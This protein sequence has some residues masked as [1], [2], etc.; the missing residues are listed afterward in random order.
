MFEDI[1]K[2]NKKLLL[3]IFISILLLGFLPKTSL[4]ALSITEPSGGR[5]GVRFNVTW[6]PDPLVPG[7]GLYYELQYVDE[8][9][10]L[11]TWEFDV[12]VTSNYYE[13]DLSLKPN[14]SVYC[15]RVRAWNSS[16]FGTWTCDPGAPPGNFAGCNCGTVIKDF[17]G[18]VWVNTSPRYIN[19]EVA[20]INVTWGVTGSPS[21]AK[22]FEVNYTVLDENDNMVYNWT[23]WDMNDMYDVLVWYG[24]VN[25]DTVDCTS[26]Y[27]DVFRPAIVLGEDLE[28]RK[29]KFRVRG[30]ENVSGY[31]PVS[32]WLDAAYGTMVDRTEPYVTIEAKRSLDGSPISDGESIMSRETVTLNVSGD[33]FGVDITGANESW[34]VWTRTSSG[35]YNEW[36]I[37]CVGEESS[38]TTTI[39]PWDDDY[40]ITVQGFSK[41]RVGNEGRSRRLGFMVM[42]P[43]SM[44]A[45]GL[46]IYLKDIFITLGSYEYVSVEVTNGQNVNENV[47]IVLLGDYVYSKFLDVPGGT[48]SPDKRRLDIGLLPLETRK[49]TVLVYT[50]KRCNN[51]NMT[52]YAESTIHVD[53][54]ETAM[55]KIN[56]VSPAEFSGLSWAGVIALLALASLAYAR[57]GAGKN[58]SK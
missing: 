43:M 58:E 55:V 5:V 41:D 46:G 33:P 13:S 51:C 30:I 26:N 37:N 31:A 48:L 17:S 20:E 47:S 24:S 19:A 56:V 45:S 23:Q 16:A 42:K 3:V 11:G 7:P 10:F 1:L 39:G 52:I 38:C 2:R 29:Y 40:N 36:S 8:G 15:F 54:N 27:T 32:V 22:C 14:G 44:T 50:S 21:D 12:N 4:A 6:T 34:M 28:N 9:N 53:I 25:Y 18:N 57:L 35:S 49:V